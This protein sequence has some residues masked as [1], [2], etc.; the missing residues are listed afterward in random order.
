MKKIVALIMT[1]IMAISCTAVIAESAQEPVVGL[2]YVNQIVV[3]GL[4]YNL[5]NTVN[6][7]QMIIEFKDDMTGYVYHESTVDNK[8]NIAWKKDD[9]GNFWYME[10]SNPIAA[11]VKVED[12]YLVIGTA[13]VAY[14]LNKE[15]IKPVEFAETVKAE[16][17]S[18]FNGKYALT[19][20]AS[21][22]YSMKAENAMEDLAALGIRNTGIQ[23]ADSND[24]S[25]LVEFFGNEPRTYLFNEE[26]GTLDMKADAN[27]EFLNVHMFKTADGGLAIN[28][29]D[30]TFYCDPITE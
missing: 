25:A 7:D 17:A 26:E 28:W 20:L 5:N 29:L 13:N 6:P 21:D 19:Y 15:P 16:K 30:L 9:D 24:T 2:W 22:G 12:G 18:D 11:P 4:A 8:A 14:V 27:L 3:D 23:I 1:L 10:E